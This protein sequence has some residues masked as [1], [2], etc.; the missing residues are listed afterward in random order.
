MFNELS[1]EDRLD[2]LYANRCIAMKTT[3]GA[4]CFE[5]TSGG[6]LQYA[7]TVVL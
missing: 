4:Y 5:K 2:N 1:K 3:V 7:P 6:V